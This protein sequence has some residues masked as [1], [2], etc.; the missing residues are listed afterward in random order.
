MR[1]TSKE[2]LDFFI[3]YSTA[4][5]KFASDLAIALEERGATVFLAPSSIEPGESF[6]ERINTAL[7]VCRMGVLLWSNAASRSQWVLDEAAALQIRRNGPERLTIHI[8]ALD[9]ASLPL[10]LSHIQKVVTAGELRPQGIAEKIYPD[11]SRK[12]VVRRA[13]I[14][15]RDL[16]DLE[17]LLLARQ[18]LVA[19]TDIAARSSAP[20]LNPL[21]KQGRRLLVRVNPS[22]LKEGG[23]V[24]NLRQAI[25]LLKIY[26]DRL[27]FYKKQKLRP[28]AVAVDFDPEIQEVTEGIEKET[29]ALRSLISYLVEDLWLV[30][31]EPVE[32][33]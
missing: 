4:D 17:C 30:S 1:E 20:V 12:Q 11:K 10:T 19:A 24:P 27:A 28:V 18:L 23:L 25:S 15:S 16:S 13:S 9:E 5:F 32:E 6:V 31:V 3:S 29:E 14:T 33:S 21:L 26:T 2:D 22:A 7:A 8:V